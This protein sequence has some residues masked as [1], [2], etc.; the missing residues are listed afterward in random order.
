MQTIL[1]D[2]RQRRRSPRSGSPRTRRARPNFD[3]AAAR[4]GK[5]H[6]IERV[7]TELRAMMPFISAG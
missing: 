5:A 4:A 6:Q 7:G 3:S 2:I 1:D